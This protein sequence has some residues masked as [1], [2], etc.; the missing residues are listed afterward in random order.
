MKGGVHIGIQLGTN[1][2]SVREVA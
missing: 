1:Q 2:K